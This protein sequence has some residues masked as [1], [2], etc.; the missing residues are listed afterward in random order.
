MAG[1]IYT[2]LNGGSCLNNNGIGVCQCASGYSG[3]YCATALGCVAGGSFACQ[4]GGACNS[5]TGICTC[6][7]GY[8]GNYCATC[9]MRFFIS[10]ANTYYVTI[11]SNHIISFT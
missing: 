1:G 6:P 3:T 7:T 8:T 5:N 2:C 9:K 11:S 4:N 10:F